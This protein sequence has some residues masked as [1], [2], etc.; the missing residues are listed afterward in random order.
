MVTVGLN[1][2]QPTITVAEGES[3][4]LCAAI[5]D[6]DL[7]DPAQGLF[8]RPAINMGLITTDQ[9]A[10]GKS[11][12]VCVCVCVCVPAC[13]CLNVCVCACTC[14]PECVCVCVRAFVSVIIISII[15][16]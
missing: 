9:T 6:S 8:Q 5:T 4:T 2:S 1:V 14:M 16:R 7:V 3:I 10:K 15:S 11:S 13:A 12:L